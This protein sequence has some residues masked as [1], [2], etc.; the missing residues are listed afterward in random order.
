MYLPEYLK[1]QDLLVCEMAKQSDDAS[2]HEVLSLGTGVD[3]W[4]GLVF[5]LQVL[6]LVASKTIVAQSII[7][8][9]VYNLLVL[10]HALT[11]GGVS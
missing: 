10:M 2:I 5:L 4:P 9:H 11:G 7:Y 1:P 3:L 8:I 6:Q